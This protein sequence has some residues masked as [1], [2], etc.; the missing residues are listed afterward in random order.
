MLFAV[1]VPY[2]YAQGNTSLSAN[3]LI[4]PGLIDITTLTEQTKKYASNFMIDPI[5]NMHEDRVFIFH[6]LNDTLVLHGCSLYLTSDRLL[7]I[8]Q[9][10]IYTWVYCL[11]PKLVYL[12][13][14]DL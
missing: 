10:R 9:T 12:N 13:G 2:Y 4:N 5:S 7:S 8:P 6:G 3:A 11:L 1:V 14:A